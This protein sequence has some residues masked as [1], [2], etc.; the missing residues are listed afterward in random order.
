[1]MATPSRIVDATVMSMLASMGRSLDGSDLCYPAS[2]GAVF[3]SKNIDI[4]GA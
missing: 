3:G 4:S 1:M 2:V